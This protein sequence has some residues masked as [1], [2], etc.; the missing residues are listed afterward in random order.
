MVDGLQAAGIRHDLLWAGIINTDGAINSIADGRLPTVIKS[1]K[2]GGIP[3]SSIPSILKANG[4][5]NNLYNDEMTETGKLQK[6]IDVFNDKK[7]PTDKW[8]QILGQ[9]G[10]FTA[11]AGGKSH[12]SMQRVLDQMKKK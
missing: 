1:M 8:E 12:R 6:I 5:I 11:I 2:D 7:I 4:F 3:E 9:D 10:A